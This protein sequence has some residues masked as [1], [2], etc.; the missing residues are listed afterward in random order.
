MSLENQPPS[1]VLVSKSDDSTLRPL[2]PER[3][4]RSLPR[5]KAV[6]IRDKSEVYGV[7]HSGN[8][9]EGYGFYPEGGERFEVETSQ[10]DEPGYSPE[11]YKRLSEEVESI[12]AQ[13]SLTIILY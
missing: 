11:F 4:E 6:E 9:S 7:Y 3:G 13:Q 2:F 8:G 1:E 10:W 12:L 5:K